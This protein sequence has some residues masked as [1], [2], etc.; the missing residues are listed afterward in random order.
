MLSTMNDT[1]PTRMSSGVPSF[2]STPQYGPRGSRIVDK[3]PMGM[4]KEE[5]KDD[6]RMNYRGEREMRVVK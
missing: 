3:R 2:K 1:A 4:D 5:Q 6:E